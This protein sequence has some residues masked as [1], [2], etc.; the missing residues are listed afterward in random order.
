MTENKKNALIVLAIVAV[1]VLL[2]IIFSNTDTMTLDTSKKKKKK[3]EPKGTKTVRV[4]PSTVKE[5][6]KKSKPKKKQKKQNEK[7]N[8]QSAEQQSCDY[9]Y[10]KIDKDKSRVLEVCSSSENNSEIIVNCS[11]NMFAQVSKE[12]QLPDSGKAGQPGKAL[13]DLNIDG[14]QW[15]EPKSFEQGMIDQTCTTHFAEDYHFSIGDAPDSEEEPFC[16]YEGKKVRWNLSVLRESCTNVEEKVRER[17]VHV[18]CNIKKLWITDDYR[19][20]GRKVI[21]DHEWS[22]PVLKEEKEII[23]EVCGGKG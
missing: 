8:D 21:K 3:S 9:Y 15:R 23:R 13:F 4:L 7:T 17:V 20:L 1:T 22:I 10:E 2:I 16:F 19:K 14:L 5:S 18:N 6:K 12:S 11:L